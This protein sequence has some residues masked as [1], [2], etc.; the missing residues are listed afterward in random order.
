[1]RIK[2]T[3]KFYLIRLDKGDEIITVLKKICQKYK[4]KAGLISG[5]G[6]LG[7]VTIG[8]F[9]PINKKYTS[10]EFIGNFELVSF[11][12]NVSVFGKETYLHLHA[13]L[14]DPR[15]RCF[16]GHLNSGVVSATFEGIIISSPGKIDRKFSPEVG[17]NLLKI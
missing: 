4:I 14:A 3:E 10:K 11:S 13:I 7:K 5:I 15:M 16:G 6:A 9:N 8:N 12:G 17:L 2:K 1:M